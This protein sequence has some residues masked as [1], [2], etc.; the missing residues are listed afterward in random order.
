VRWL[1]ALPLGAGGCL[2]LPV[3]DTESN[4][5]GL[6]AEPGSGPST[7]ASPEGWEELEDE[8]VRLVNEERAR[9]GRCGSTPFP[10]SAPLEEDLLLREL[11]RDF[12]RRMAE[13]RFFDHVDPA[14]DDPFDRMEA[15]GFQGEKPW[16]EN[17]AAGYFTAEE[18]VDGWMGSPGHCQN[19]LEPAFAVIG[20]GYYRRDDDP[21]RMVHYWTQEFAASH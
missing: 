10:P 8:V 5:S 13:E 2:F 18:V 17:I 14:G 20:V 15:A 6:F 19:L 21:E 1:V 9:G 16:G 7:G 4:D 12:S 11:A 3:W